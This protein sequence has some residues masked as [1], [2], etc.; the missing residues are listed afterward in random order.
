MPKGV[1]DANVKTEQIF[2]DFLENLEND[3]D[4][5]YLGFLVQF[6]TEITGSTMEL[7]TDGYAPVVGVTLY[8]KQIPGGKFEIKFRPHMSSN[9]EI[10]RELKIEDFNQRLKDAIYKFAVEVWGMTPVDERNDVR[11][12]VQATADFTAQWGYYLEKEKE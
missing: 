5:N 3:K 10:Y 12:S 4:D 11:E 6:I 7:G 2:K 9:M 1:R 8:A